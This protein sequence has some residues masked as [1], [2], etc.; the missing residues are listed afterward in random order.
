MKARFSAGAQTGPEVHSTSY[1]MGT[2]TFPGVMR[3]GCGVDN[4]PAFR[5]KVKERVELYLYYP[6]GPSSLV[7]G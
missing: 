4:P 5:A 1:T 3:P 7:L 2:G 6:S